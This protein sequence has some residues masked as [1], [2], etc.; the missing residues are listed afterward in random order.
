MSG[1]KPKILA[2][3]IY[4]LVDEKTKILPSAKV[5]FCKPSELPESGA[6]YVLTSEG[7]HIAKDSPIVKG[8]VPLVSEDDSLRRSLANY[9]KAGKL[10]LPKIPPLV[11]ARAWAFFARVWDAYH[12]ESE[13]ML[14][15]CQDTKEYDLWCPQ[16]EVS[17][18][19]VHYDMG[20]QLQSMKETLRNRGQNWQWVGTIH[21]HCNF[22]AYHSGTDIDDEKD[23]DGIHITIGHVDRKACSMAASAVI[24][25][26]RW[27]LKIPQVCLG[28]ESVPGDVGRGYFIS[29]KDADDFYQISLTKADKAL[30]EGE[31]GKQISKEWMPQVTK[32]TFTNHAWEGWEDVSV[33]TEKYAAAEPEEDGDWRLK[34]G[35]WTFLTSAQAELLDEEAAKDA[36]IE[37]LGGLNGDNSEA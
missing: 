16:Q 34:D 6:Y 14:L 21:S 11:L 23:S 1:E 31:F 33:W 7:L 28:I 22:S 8:V 32:Q 9:H 15:Y 29:T 20:Q 12:A 37:N 17:G 18:A 13:V 26:Q 36:A 35:K 10:R 25:K 3:P 24:G 5:Q 27:E 30:L 2:L 4:V 19:S